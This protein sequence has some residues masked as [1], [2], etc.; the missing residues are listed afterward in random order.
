MDISMAI[1]QVLDDEPRVWFAFLF[2]SRGRGSARPG[3]DWDI[4]VYLDDSLDDRQKL[5]IRRGLSAQL[6]GPDGPRVDLV[7]LN[8]APPLLAHRALKGREL[9]NKNRDTYVSFFTRVI[10]EVED[11]RHFYR[12][13][14]RA[15]RDR[16]AEGRFGRP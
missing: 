7:V 14:E 13:H 16:L 1:R 5:D 4:A 9:V 3:S 8:D 2:G 12:V 11:E 15:R 10:G 6:S